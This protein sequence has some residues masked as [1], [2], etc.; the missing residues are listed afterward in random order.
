MQNGHLSY[1]LRPSSRGANILVDANGYNY[2]RKKESGVKTLWV[3]VNSQKSSCPAVVNVLKCTNILVKDDSSC[4]HNHDNRR[5]ATKAIVNEKKQNAAVNPNLMPR[6]VM[7]DI[8]ISVL[9]SDLASIGCLPKKENLL[10]SIRIVKQKAQGRPASPK[11]L[12]E[13]F[14]MPAPFTVTSDGNKFLQKMAYT[15]EHET[16]AMVL[17]ISEAG[18]NLLA[19]HSVWTGDGTFATAPKLFKQLYFIG[20]VADSGRFIPAAYS[21]LTNKTSDTYRELFSAVIDVVGNVDHVEK[22]SC[23][24]EIA[25]HMIVEE[26]FPNAAP[27]GCLFHFNQAVY[28]NIKKKGCMPVYNNVAAFR[29]LLSNIY[30]LAYVPPQEV[31]N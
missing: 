5:E 26:L 24:F 29:T 8:T 19:N 22:F 11:E 23:D 9:N 30:S 12:S 14:N 28:D 27:S 31:R 13:L 7:A 1:T 15:D 17:F 20:V 6:A 4:I 16:Q 25:V 3:C 18:K 21:L 2:Y 10:R